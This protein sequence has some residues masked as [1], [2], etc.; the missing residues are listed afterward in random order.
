MVQ[1]M[2]IDGAFESLRP[3]LAGKHIKSN[4]CFESKH[5]G[6]IERTNQT[7]KERCR[8]ILN[9]IPFQRLPGRMI[10][11]LF[12]TAVFCFNDF[13]PSEDFLN[14]LS[15]STIM[16]GQTIDFIQKH[17]RHEYSAY[18]Q[19]YESSDNLMQLRMTG[20]IALR[21][22]ETNREVGTTSH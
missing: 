18:V 15:P 5:V 8:G 22:Q 13:H 6:K 14:N 20:A 3:A 19:A 1:H 2:M 16:T 11:K 9:T 7:I 4:I 12:Y 21:L 10:V 17:C